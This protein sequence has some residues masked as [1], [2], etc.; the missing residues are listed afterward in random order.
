M[1][2]LFGRR[3]RERDQRDE[4]LSAYLDGELSEREQERL[5]ARLSEDPALRAEL[6]AMHHTVSMVRDLPQVRAPRNFILSES[7]VKEQ[8]G[9]PETRAQPS[10]SPRRAWAA[11]LLTAAATAMSLLFVIVLMGDLL[12]PGL[13]GLASPPAPLLQ[14]EEPPQIAMEAAPTQEPETE[15]FGTADTASPPPELTEAPREETLEEP[16]MAIRE[17]G[18]EDAAAATRAAQA[19]LGAGATPPPAITSVTIHTPTI[20]A[21]EPVVSEEELGQV[22]PS[23]E[24]LEVTPKL[25]REEPAAGRADRPPV[26]WTLLEVALGL[27]SLVLVGAAF[28]AW[29]LRGR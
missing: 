13:G 1:L 11:P 22:E 14:S 23:P 25:E 16:E 4:L 7:M 15:A 3:E 21:E 2:P 5:E 24:E 26:P 28:R 20:P 27:A 17:E 9:A 12:I 10:G 19:P 29:R 6:R 8:R 18:E